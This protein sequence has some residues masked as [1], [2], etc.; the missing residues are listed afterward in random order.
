MSL[1]DKGW[2]L[3]VC[4]G[5]H[6]SRER[7]CVLMGCEES[8]AVLGADLVV[9]SGGLDREKTTWSRLP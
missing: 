1:K 6:R 4:R 3:P 8:A 7:W 9:Q 5:K 2:E